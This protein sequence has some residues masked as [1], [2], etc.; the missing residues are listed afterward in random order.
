MH[1]ARSIF[2]SDCLALST[3]KHYSCLCESA[4]G[5]RSN[6][7]FARDTTRDVATEHTLVL[8]SEKLPAA[9][10]KLGL[11]LTADPDREAMFAFA[12][13]NAPRT[14]T[15]GDAGALHVAYSSPYQ[16]DFTYDEAQGKYLAALN[17]KPVADDTGA[18]AAYTNVLVLYT[19]TVD[20]HDKD[21]HLDL[22]L[23]AGGTGL[24]LNGGLYERILW[25]KEED[26]APLRLLTEA[27]EP[28][29][30]NPGNS[31]IGFVRSTNEDK[32]TIS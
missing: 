22:L 9:M 27:G 32:T 19:E 29:T 6:D 4:G 11:D 2:G 1:L 5:F 25:E 8:L 14:L 3:E 10:E 15:G 7:C 20:L 12:D 17:E 23:E 31:Y 21:G 16:Y 28:L 18:A 24:Y 30:L 26:A 13:G